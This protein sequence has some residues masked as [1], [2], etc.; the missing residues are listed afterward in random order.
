[1]NTTLESLQQ[2]EKLENDKIEH[3]HSLIRKLNQEIA[4]QQE[5]LDRASKQV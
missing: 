2:E 1:M 5:K 3:K 4:S